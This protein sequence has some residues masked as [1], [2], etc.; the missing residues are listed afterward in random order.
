MN[1]QDEQIAHTGNGINTSRSTAFR[2]ILQFA[3]DRPARARFVGNLFGIA[4]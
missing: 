3:I 2:P 1:E 4:A